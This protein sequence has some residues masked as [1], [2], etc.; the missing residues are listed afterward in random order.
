[1]NDSPDFIRLEQAISDAVTALPAASCQGTDAALR[2]A[3]HELVLLLRH[4]QERVQDL[5]AMFAARG[6]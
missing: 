6:S 3:C 4:T 1:M 2:R 5:R